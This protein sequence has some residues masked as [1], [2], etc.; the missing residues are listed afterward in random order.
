MTRAEAATLA[1]QLQAALSFPELDK[2]NL[3]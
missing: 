1:D 3:Q 2:E